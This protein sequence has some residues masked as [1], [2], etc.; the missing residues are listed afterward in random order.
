M[1][2]F[3]PTE[4]I[5]VTGN[6]VRESISRSTISRDEAIGFFNLDPKKKSILSVGGSLG[7]K[8]INEALAAHLNE[9]EK[10]DLQLIWQTGRPFLASAKEI[11]V[12]KP[13]IWVNDFITKME[14]AYAAAD[15]VIS[16]SGAMAIT[17]LCV[18]KKAALF[19]PY[20]FAA[21]DHQTANAKKLVNK[22][23]GMMIKDSEALDTLVP[24]I[25]ALIRDEEKLETLKMNI[26]KLAITD[27][28][29][30]IAKNILSL[31][32]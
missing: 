28:D 22:N 26:E 13:N 20:P 3:F 25:I 24:A 19:V 27:A 11:A 2:K 9:F 15:V 32:T 29:E 16:R 31:I 21:E 12:G 4:K 7:A 8:S 23:A 18:E 10:N 17:E 1:E 5:L 30:V 14:Y 6:P